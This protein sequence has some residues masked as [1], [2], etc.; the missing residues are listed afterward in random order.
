MTPDEYIAKLSRLDALMGDDP[1]PETEAGAELSALAE[2]L[3]AYEKA[4]WP[5]LY[6]PS[7]FEDSSFPDDEPTDLSPGTP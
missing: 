7:E 5:N 6:P 2:E 4:T 1:E 3:E